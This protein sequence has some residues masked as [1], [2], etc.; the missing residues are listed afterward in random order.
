[1]LKKNIQNKELIQKIFLET[2]NWENDLEKWA[3][4]KNGHLRKEE[5]LMVNKY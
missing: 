2:C 4:D 5:I 3:K 1:M